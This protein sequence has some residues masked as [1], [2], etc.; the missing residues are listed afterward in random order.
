MFL[1]CINKVYVCLYVCMYV[2]MYV[3]VCVCVCV[4]VCMYD[5]LFVHALEYAVIKFIFF[6]SVF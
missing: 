5:M 1:S 2:C 4:Y 6:I 3:C